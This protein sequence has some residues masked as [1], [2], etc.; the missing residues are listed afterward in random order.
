MAK[1]VIMSINA[2][3]VKLRFGSRVIIISLK[4]L[5]TVHSVLYDFYNP[6]LKPGII[7]QNTND[8][9]T[10][11]TVLGTSETAP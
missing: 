5:K 7:N 11:S 3:S 4:P 9:G 8:P 2:L 10:V 1:P 6:R